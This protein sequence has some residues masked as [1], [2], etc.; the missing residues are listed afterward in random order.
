MAWAD[1]AVER[2][3]ALGVASD[4]DGAGL[5]DVRS[6]FTGLRPQG[7]V[8]AGGS[9]RLVAT[10]DSWCAVNLP[11]PD[12][13]DLLPAWLGVESAAGVV[14]W[15]EVEAVA[16]TRPSAGLVGAGQELG[17][18]VAALGGSGPDEQLRF[19]GTESAAR[20]WLVRRVAARHS[21]RRPEDVVVVDLSS[22][23]AGPSCARLLGRAGARIVKVES[24]SRPDGSRAGDRRFHRWLHE[25]HELV[26]VDFASDEGRRALIDIVH[27]ADVVIEASRPRAFERLG[28]D[29]VEVVSAR[30]G[31][32]WVSITGYGRCGPWRNRVAF[33]DDAAVAG[34]LVELD[35][36]GAPLFVAD[37]VADPLT[38]VA[39][40]ALTV[41]ALA[42]GGGVTVD[43]ALR[44]VARSAAAGAVVVW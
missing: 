38:G 44:E 2:L 19:R 9:C 15:S 24:S 28:I 41:G 10:T 32:V 18:A 13:L 35:D 20:P 16:A 11:R 7:R 8:S 22:L 5:L 31:T 1:R 42:A 4:L 30:P 23:W 25:G 36:D 17:L 29:P 14:P 39:A 40:A 43:V 21:T 26:E 3:A 34:G 33:G 27:S 6:T 37:A 12:D